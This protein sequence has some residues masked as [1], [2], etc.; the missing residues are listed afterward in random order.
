[1]ENSKTYVCLIEVLVVHLGSRSGA[2]LNASVAY[3]FLEG[4]RINTQDVGADVENCK[5]GQ[6]G[7]D[8]H[9]NTYQN[10]V[11]R[12][13][14]MQANLELAHS[15]PT[16]RDK[17]RVRAINVACAVVGLLQYVQLLHQYFVPLS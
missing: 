5:R 12:F 15:L 4:S 17:V 9:R 10:T 1:M 6:N 3:G 2:G 13:P 11:P 7:R 14:P 8:Q 16:R